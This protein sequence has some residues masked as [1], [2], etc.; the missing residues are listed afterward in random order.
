MTRVDD[1]SRARRFL[2]GIARGERPLRG[3]VVVVVAH[4]DDETIGCGG[5]LQRLADV[6]LVHITDGAP[7]NADDA[8]HR[9]FDTPAAYA[10]ARAGELRAAM[11][12]I[13]LPTE[14]LIGLGRADQSAAFELAPITRRLEP[15]LA[16]ADVVVTHAYEGGHPDHDAVAFAV[17]AV[18]ARLRA[19]GAAPDLVE[20]PLYHAI[21]EGWATQRF[22]PGPGEPPTVLVLSEG[23]RRIKQHMLTAHR[24]QSETLA[25]FTPADECF[26][27][28]RRHD[29]D[30]LPNAGMLIYERHDWGLRGEQWLELVATARNVLAPEKAA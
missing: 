19:G 2:D 20:M 14:R 9:A 24:S 6:T 11:A 26:R 23:E 28:V 22:A 17:D 25:R 5:L 3:R 1:V 16:G 12:L 8:A 27:V 18:C 4:P 15:I 7:R 10:A 29:F 21:A 30:I 13:G